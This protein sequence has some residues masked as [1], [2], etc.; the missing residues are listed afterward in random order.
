MSGSPLSG[1]HWMEIDLETAA[2]P[3]RFVLDWEA[4]HADVY[5]IQGRLS[6]TVSGAFCAGPEAR[7]GGQ[8]R[9]LGGSADRSVLWEGKIS[10]YPS[11]SLSLF[12]PLSLSPLSPLCTILLIGSRRRGHLPVSGP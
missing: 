11:R 8:E 10:L 9:V 7:L 5:S 1:T 4:A 2:V 3:T 12:L 6:K